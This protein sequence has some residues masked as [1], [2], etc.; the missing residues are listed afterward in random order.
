MEPGK[1]SLNE[2]PAGGTPGRSCNSATAVGKR[3][4]SGLG[5]HSI[6]YL[7][8]S[9]RDVASLLVGSSSGGSAQNRANWPGER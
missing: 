8:N 6:S 7:R 1:H 5:R 9:L 2:P 3:G 4:H